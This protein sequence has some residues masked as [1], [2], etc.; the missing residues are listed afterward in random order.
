MG[1][2]TSGPKG[3]E[4]KSEIK[5]GFGHGENSATNKICGL[6]AIRDSRIALTEH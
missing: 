3:R 6:N 1:Q 2:L 4:Q 5:V